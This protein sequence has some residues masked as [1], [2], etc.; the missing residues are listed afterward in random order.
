MGALELDQ[1]VAAALDAVPPGFRFAVQ[2]G[3]GDQRA[4]PFGLRIAAA[5]GGE[6]EQAAVLDDQSQ[7]R[8]ALG[9]EPADPGLAVGELAGGGPQTSRATQRP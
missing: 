5:G 2:G 8:S 4:V 7:P 1:E 9:I 3:D 6:D